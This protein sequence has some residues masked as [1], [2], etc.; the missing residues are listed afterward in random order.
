MVSSAYLLEESM[1][2]KNIKANKSRLQLFTSDNLRRTLKSSK[3]ERSPEDEYFIY[4]S[5]GI[6]KKTITN[7]VR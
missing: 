5:Q 4:K 6:S 2:S 1:V 7:K 3:S